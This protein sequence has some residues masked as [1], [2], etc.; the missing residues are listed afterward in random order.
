MT[1]LL[2]SPSTASCHIYAPAL[3][4]SGAPC[5]PG[6]ASLRSATVKV[7]IIS[8]ANGCLGA[9]RRGTY[10]VD[11]PRQGRTDRLLDRNDVRM[12]KTVALEQQWL[13]ADLGERVGETV[14]VVQACPMTALSRT[15]GRPLGRSRLG[16]RRPRQDSP[17]PG[18]A[19]SNSRPPDSPKRLSITMAVS[20]YDAVDMVRTG[21]SATLASKSSASGSSVSMA[22]RAE[23]SMTIR[24]AARGP[25]S[26]RSPPQIGRLRP[27]LIVVRDLE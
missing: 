27:D 2:A 24:T 13:T 20:R 22:T 3:T 15:A 6:D 25:R 5:D 12:P 19:R 14:A 23:A 17:M 16:R 9:G 11:Q 26:P 21:S 4:I 8:A 7:P 18:A 10:T 1:L